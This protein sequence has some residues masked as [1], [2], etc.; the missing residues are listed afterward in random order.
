MGINP[1]T[2]G[3]ST[4]TVFD[5]NTDGLFDSQDDIAVVNG[6]AVIAGTRF[7]AIPTDSTFMGNQRITQLI[8]GRV[9]VILTNTS[10]SDFI[11]RQSWREVEIE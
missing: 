3:E 10:N 1:G 6:S 7:N 11:G 4:R 5:I 2:G 9:D 8:D